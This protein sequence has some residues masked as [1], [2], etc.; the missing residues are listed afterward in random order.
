[1]HH[2]A[3]VAVHH[4][5]QVVVDPIAVVVVVRHTGPEADTVDSAL[6]VV[7]S[8]GEVLVDTVAADHRALA[9]Y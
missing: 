9:G 7:R 2:I 5:V 4:T 8:L 3:H 6:V 1:M